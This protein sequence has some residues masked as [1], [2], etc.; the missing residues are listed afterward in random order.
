VYRSDYLSAF[1]TNPNYVTPVYTE[2][3]TT[4]DLSANYAITKNFGVTFTG[5]NLTGA[6]RRDYAY[7]H[8]AF[9]NYYTVP[10]ILALSLR[11]SF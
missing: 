9:L 7:N 11:A 8:A 6:N 10:R 3:S 1:P 4:L 2:G 5:S